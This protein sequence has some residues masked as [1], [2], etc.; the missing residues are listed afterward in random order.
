MLLSDIRSSELALLTVYF[1]LLQFFT[2]NNVDIILPSQSNHSSVPVAPL[3]PFHPYEK[4]RG[5][6]KYLRTTNEEKE[7]FRATVGQPGVTVGA[8]LGLALSPDG[9]QLAFQHLDAGKLK[10]LSV[11]GG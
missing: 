5:P 6:A 3:W 2:R 8:I 4:N 7:L 9:K 1:T 10:V 11:A